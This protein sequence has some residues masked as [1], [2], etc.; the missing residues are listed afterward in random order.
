MSNPTVAE[1]IVRRLSD[2]GIDKAFGVPS[3]YAFPIADAI[4]ASPNMDWVGCTNELNAAYAVDGYARLKGA[5]LLCAAYGVGELSLVNGLMA[6]RAHRVPVFFVTGQPSRRITKQRLIS[7]HT[8]GDGVYGNFEHIIEAACCA[9]AVISPDN[10]ID[11]MERVIREALSQSQPAYMVVLHDAQ[12]VPVIGT[13]VTGEP[14][15]KV[16]RQV[17]VT[18]ELEGALTAI[19]NQLKNAHNPVVLP[20]ALTARYGLRDKIEQFIETANIPFALSPMD[21]G[22]LDEQSPLYLGLYCGE[23]STPKAV[24]HAVE[25][26]D[27][28]LDLGG[29]V[30]EAENTGY[31]TD[32]LPEEQVVHICDNWVRVGTKVFVNL[33]LEDVIDGLIARTPKFAGRHDPFTYDLMPLAGDDTDPISSAAFYP[34]VQRMLQNDDVLVIEAGSGQF[35]E[36]AFRLPG[37]VRSEAMCLWSSIGWGTPAALGMA[38]AEPERRVIL[39]TGDGA[40]QMTINALA[41]M[42]HHDA[43]PVIFVLNNGVYGCEITLHKEGMSYNNLPELDYSKIPEAFGC[44]GW[45]TK[46]VATVKDLDEA[47]DELKAHN[48]GAYI[49][50]MIPES[51][52]EPLPANVL[53]AMYKLKTPTP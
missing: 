6:S 52:S 14:L 28:I 33:S 46:R 47:L 34:R 48:N 16:K 23:Q 10:A 32:A 20:T 53:D 37:Q 36:A 3:D 5:G 2:L 38:M 29:V 39:I 19:V 24:T 11:E 31:W 49:E 30:M 7:K 17:S 18:A 51:E 26:A 1:Y 13:P 8:L 15:D 21:K 44:G 50:V 9:K 45:L 43:K 25:G 4:E 12:D 41:D 35:V 27:V 22:F 42:G 40:H